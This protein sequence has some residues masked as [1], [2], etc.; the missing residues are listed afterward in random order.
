MFSFDFY[1]GLAEVVPNLFVSFLWSMKTSIWKKL[2]PDVV[3]VG[4][5]WKFAASWF[6]VQELQLILYVISCQ[7]LLT[8]E[9][10]TRIIENPSQLGFTVTLYSE[11]PSVC[12]CVRV[13]TFVTSF[14]I[15]LHYMMFQTI[16]TIYF[17]KAYHLCICASEHQWI[18]FQ[19]WIFF[20]M[21][22]FQD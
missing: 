4:F 7:P 12:M 22:I 8:F 14:S 20:R 11:C 17:L 16:Q 10:R 5:S 2:S 13:C 3:G 1:M 18:F 19:G 9:T 21:N 6:L 15:C